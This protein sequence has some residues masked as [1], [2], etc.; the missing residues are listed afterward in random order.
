MDLKCKPL[1]T[2]MKTNGGRKLLVASVDH[3][4]TDGGCSPVN[5]AATSWAD[6]SLYRRGA[7]VSPE[8][9]RNTIGAS[10]VWSLSRNFSYMCLYAAQYGFPQRINIR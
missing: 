8:R 1:Q 3:L 7:S 2:G 5:T 6:G 10:S 4:A 9:K